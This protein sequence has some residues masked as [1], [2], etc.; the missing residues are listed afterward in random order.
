MALFII[1]QLR[2]F[3]FSNHHFHVDIYHGIRKE[4]CMMMACIRF[5]WEKKDTARVPIAR[6]HP[7]LAQTFVQELY[8]IDTAT[9]W[10]VSIFVWY[11][12]SLYMGPISRKVGNGG[13]LFHFISLTPCH[14]KCVSHLPK[15]Q[16]WRTMVLTIHTV[17]NPTTFEET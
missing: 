12:C 5:A 8:R 6:V 11:S 3:L 17:A 7:Q 14:P 10:R 13:S 9:K 16:P 2:V 1:T 15:K 4:A